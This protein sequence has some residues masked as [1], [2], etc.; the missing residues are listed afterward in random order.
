VNE[1][2]RP[3]Q[4]G[5][6]SRTDIIKHGRLEIDL[7]RAGNVFLVGGFGEVDIDWEGSARTFVSG[8]TKDPI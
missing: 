5:H 3:E 4:P 7:D 1:R 6:R 8:R 2:I